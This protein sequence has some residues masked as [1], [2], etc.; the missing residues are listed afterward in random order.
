M[1]NK[2]LSFKDSTNIR[3]TFAR[4]DQ[5][6]ELTLKKTDLGFLT[7]LFQGEQLNQR[8]LS[9]LADRIAIMNENELFLL[10]EAEQSTQYELS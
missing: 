2:R 6:L 9:D 1:G 3:L 8:T 7:S 5:N 4:N 10:R